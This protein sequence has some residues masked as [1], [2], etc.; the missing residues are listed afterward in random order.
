MVVIGVAVVEL[1]IPHAQ[2][3]KGK[4]R[5]IKGLIDRLHKR[6]RISI[7]ETDYQDLHQ[8]SQI[9]VAI[10]GTAE[11]ET[12]DRLETFH[13]NIEEVPELTITRW[14]SELIVGLD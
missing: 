10:V 11:H 14:N 2:S 1:H 12:D 4:R 3:L 6:H 13:R 7:A 9:T 8:R 5:V